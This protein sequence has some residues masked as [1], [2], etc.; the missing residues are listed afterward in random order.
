METNQ[1]IKAQN[2]LNQW[3]KKLVTWKDKKKTD[4]F[5]ARLTKKKK[6]G[7]KYLN[8]GIKGEL[9]PALQKQ[10]GK[11]NTMNNCTSVNKT[12]WKK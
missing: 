2:F 10:K 9:L 4:K 11:R 5:L 7:F 6:G 8:S 1:K 3:N 12:T